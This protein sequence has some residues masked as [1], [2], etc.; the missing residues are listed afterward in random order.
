MLAGELYDANAPELVEGRTRARRLLSAYNATDAADREGRTHLLA[1]LVGSHGDGVWIEPPF[2]CD[3]GSNITLG[4]RAYLNFD[5]VVLDCAPVSI[6][7]G[8]MLGPAV[9]IYAATHP[10]DA[11]ARAEGREY[12]LPVTIGT[13][14]WIGGAVVILPGVTIGDR[15]VIAAGSVVTRDVPDGVVVGGNPGRIVRRLEEAG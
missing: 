11:A 4:D 10:V 6:G 13:D 14:V 7:A 5:C 8:T 15:S 9:Q 1:Q 12:A 3:Y 2:Y